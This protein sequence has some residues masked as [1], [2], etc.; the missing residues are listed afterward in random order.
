MAALPPAAPD[1]PV[2]PLHH[3]PAFP[4]VVALPPDTYAPSQADLKA[5]GTSGGVPLPVRR[6]LAP[7][8]ESLTAEQQDELLDAADAARR[9]Q[10]AA[11]AL[12]A[13]LEGR[14]YDYGRSERYV[15]DAYETNVLWSDDR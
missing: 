1:V 6:A 4:A 3:T 11:E 8:A 7:S 9:A 12:S 14:D 13:V 15:H 2:V 5:W 10:E